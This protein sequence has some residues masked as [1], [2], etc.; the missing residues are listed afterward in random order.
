MASADVA[1][2]D[3][4]IEFEADSTQRTASLTAAGGMVSNVGV[5]AAA[6]AK[7]AISP[8]GNDIVLTQPAGPGIIPLPV[9]ATVRLPTTC[10]S[11][12]FKASAS[13]FLVYTKN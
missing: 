9:G 3:S 8:C 6:G 1:L 11:F 7:A 13:T 10:R 12:T 4:G 5:D 2:T